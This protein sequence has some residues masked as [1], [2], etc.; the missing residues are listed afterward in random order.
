MRVFDPLGLSEAFA[1]RENLITQGTDTLRLYSGLSDGTDGLFVDRFAGFISATLYDPLMAGAA[2]ALAASLESLFPGAAVLVKARKD[3]FTNQYEY[4][5][6]PLWRREQVLTS[7]EG[8]LRYEIHSDPRHDYGL[9][10]DTKAA[11]SALAA[12]SGGKTILNLFSYTCAFAVA[13]TEAGG[14]PVNIDPSRDYL[15]WGG[16]NAALNKQ[17]FLRY[18][19]TTQGYL[20]RHLRRLES[21]KDKP[22]D[23]CVMDP[24]AFLVGRGSE[25]LARNMWKLWADQLKKCQCRRFM[26][27]FNDKSPQNRKEQQETLLK[28]FD[29]AIQFEELAQS[30]DV[31]GQQLTGNQDSFYLSPSVFWAIRD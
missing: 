18:V 15:D 13:A 7:C 29:Y 24:P 23:I 19:D 2:A 22:Y 27:V 20:A 30:P 3:A 6:N 9:Y 5:H 14:K 28:I 11:R 17:T 1:F 21:G 12:E 8:G 25:R 31:L 26:L 10:T 4:L 16:R